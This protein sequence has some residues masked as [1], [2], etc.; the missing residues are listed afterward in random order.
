MVTSIRTKSAVE[1][2]KDLQTADSSIITA[3]SVSL[4]K[5]PIVTPVVRPPGSGVHVKSGR[6]S[7]SECAETGVRSRLSPSRV[8]ETER[9]MV[10]HDNQY[11]PPSDDDYRSIDY[12]IETMQV[13]VEGG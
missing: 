9:L 10:K 4:A 6:S 2:R 5:G 7:H 12:Q 11:Q 1:G 13:G 3:M 8:F